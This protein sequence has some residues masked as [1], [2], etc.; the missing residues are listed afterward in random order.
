[1]RERRRYKRKLINARVKLYHPS[2][3]AIEG[4]TRDISDGGLFITIQPVPDV[5]PG[6]EVKLLLL[7]SANPGVIFTMRV[8]RKE[9]Q[10]LGLQFESFEEGGRK[11]SIRELRKRWSDNH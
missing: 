4:T 8:I 2:I 10:G 6:D 3:D 11:G 1:M 5:K 9:Q 7:E